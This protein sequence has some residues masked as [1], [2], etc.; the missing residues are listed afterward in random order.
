IYD[1]QEGKPH[2]RLENRVLPGGPTVADTLANAVFF[3]G[4]IVDMVDD[5][6]PVWSRM[7]F[8]TA[9][10]NLMSAARHG[11]DARLYWP[12]YGEV[13][14]E[15]LAMRQLLPSAERGLARLGIDK[16]VPQTYL[17]IVGGRAR[18]GRNGASW[19]IAA[20]Q[21]FESEGANRQE[22]L[23]QM[24]RAYARHMHSNQPV[25]EWPLP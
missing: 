5:E 15:E 3:F 2:L 21:H 17:G 1:V 22:A 4:A 7:S 8:D 20:V 23:E 6:R 24:V 13:P 12:G 9:W 16:P 18:T 25:H 11:I 10:R 14:I 19:Q